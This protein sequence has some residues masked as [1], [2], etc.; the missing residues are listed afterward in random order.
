MTNYREAQEQG[1]NFHYAW[2]LLS[3]LLV[4]GELLKGSQFPNIE[5]NLPEAVRYNSL[6]ATKDATRVH[7]IKVF[8]IFMEASIQRL[9]DCILWL[10]LI[11]YNNLQSLVEFKADMH[12]LYI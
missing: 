7:E 6:W 5:K 1:K 8:W 2:L 11:V 12:N 3:I 10:S 4:V 9:I